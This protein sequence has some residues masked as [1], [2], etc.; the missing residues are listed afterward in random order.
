MEEQTLLT[1][2]L[3][4]SLLNCETI[5]EREAINQWMCLFSTFFFSQVLRIESILSVFKQKK[6]KKNVWFSF[7]FKHLPTIILAK[8]DFV[9]KFWNKRVYRFSI[10]FLTI[11][12]IQRADK[13]GQLSEHIFRSPFLVPRHENHSA[14]ID[15]YE[16]SSL[17]HFFPARRRLQQWEMGNWFSSRESCLGLIKVRDCTSTGG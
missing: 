1:E 16:G 17:F 6:N 7:I 4:Q 11:F 15:F 3:N 9:L 13:E 12:S 14:V 5:F 8:R 10:Q 2:L